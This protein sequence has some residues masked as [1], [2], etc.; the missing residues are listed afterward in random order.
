MSDAVAADDM[1]T[2]IALGDTMVILM[3]QHNVKEEGILY[4][5]IEQHIEG[6]MQEQ[7]FTLQT[8]MAP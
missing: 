7:I 5:M 2:A 3:Q 6:L 1:D 8:Y 4:P